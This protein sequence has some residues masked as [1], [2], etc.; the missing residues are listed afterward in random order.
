MHYSFLPEWATIL[1]QLLAVKLP[2]DAAAS[3]MSCGVAKLSRAITTDPHGGRVG[4]RH[5]VRPHLARAA[6]RRTGYCLFCAGFSD[7]LG[8]ACDLPRP[9]A[10]SDAKESVW[11][12]TDRFGPY[13][14]RDDSRCFALKASVTSTTRLAI[15]AAAA[16]IA[17]GA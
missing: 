7:R 15:T 1:R 5:R 13:V 16:R 8:D 4:S 3:T 11:L 14:I 12:K 6:I 9:A 17:R 2:I 10:R